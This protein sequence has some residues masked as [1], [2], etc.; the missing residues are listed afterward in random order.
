VLAV[1]GVIVLPITSGDTAFRVARLITAD[2]LK[3][4][5]KLKTN[6]YRIAIP[7]FLTSAALNFIPFD[8]IWRYFGWANQTLSA[9]TL[10]CGAVFLARRGRYWWL[11]AGP[12]TFMTIMTTTY[13]LTAGEGLGLSQ[14]TGTLIGLGL[15]AAALGTFLYFLPRLEPEDEPPASS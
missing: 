10:W 4:P 11:A 12:A 2:Y 8:I 3:L 6:R 1:L 14:T 15:G 7:L 9:V 13:I 5:Q